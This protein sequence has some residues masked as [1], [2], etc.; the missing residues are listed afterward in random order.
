MRVKKYLKVM[1]LGSDAIQGLASCSNGRRMLSPKLCSPPA[2]SCAAPMIP[3]P[4][5]VITI[6]PS[7]TIR[8]P[9]SR[10]AS[11]A[12]SV[13]GVRAEPK[14]VT[15]RTARYGANTL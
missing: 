3:A 13:G 8:R 7:C 9:N 4:A 15:L 14:T 5:P 1:S 12:G 6:Q 11:A 10:A 2:P